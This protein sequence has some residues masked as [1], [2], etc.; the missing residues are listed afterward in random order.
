MLA[1]LLG[2]PIIL[3]TLGC[4][5]RSPQEPI[6]LS[7]Q[8][9]VVTESTALRT[10]SL[11]ARRE[12][13]PIGPLAR[14]KG[15]YA[16]SADGKRLFIVSYNR[17]DD[18]ALSEIDLV[19]R[20]V[21][22]SIRL[23]DLPS[24][25][26]GTTTTIGGS[27]SLSLDS[28]GRFA[29]IGA[30]QNLAGL[31]VALVDLTSQTI[32]GFRDVGIPLASVALPSDTPGAPEF[33]VVAIA[34]QGAS[35][36]LNIYRLQAPSLDVLDS[37]VL[38]PATSSLGPFGDMAFVSSNSH[39]LVHLGGVVLQVAAETLAITGT[40]AVAIQAGHLAVSPFGDRVV[41]VDP[42]D[43]RIV[44]GSGIVVEFDSSLRQVV[45]HRLPPMPDGS[46]RSAQHATYSVDGSRILLTTGT[47]RVGPL[48]VGQTGD[49]YQIE[50][51]SGL[52]SLAVPIGEYALGRIF[53][54]P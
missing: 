3:P 5:S 10:W 47:P 25:G 52:V 48:F 2:G 9:T 41:L 36:S 38:V 49:V 33:A 45:H 46:S 40:L 17:Y 30:A 44:P 27:V 54:L 39:L 50:R 13:D 29:L 16:L 51:Q 53:L 23:A 14:A 12:T 43:Y 42:G 35:Q 31:G 24:A 6:G 1:W 32:V 4:S 22:R 21:G 26:S 18:R 34:R 8:V 37:S 15:P 20:S 7:A 11:E 28:S 19:S